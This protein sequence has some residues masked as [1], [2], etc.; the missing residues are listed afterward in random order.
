VD[1]EGRGRSEGRGGEGRGGEGKEGVSV[2][3][4]ISRAHSFLQCT[5]GFDD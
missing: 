5:D 4:L 3:R 2:E 1:V